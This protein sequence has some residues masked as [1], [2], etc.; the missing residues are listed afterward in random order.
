[1][2]GL[3]GRAPTDST[4]GP[5]ATERRGNAALTDRRGIDAPTPQPISARHD[6]CVQIGEAIVY[7]IR[8]PQAGSRRLIRSAASAA[9]ETANAASRNQPVLDPDLGK[10]A[11]GDP[12]HPR[13]Q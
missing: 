2:A 5:V 1:M 9:R 11:L 3:G 4:T 8:R 6:R 13:R 12:P 10:G 7:Q